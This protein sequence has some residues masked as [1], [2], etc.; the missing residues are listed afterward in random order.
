MINEYKVV[1]K[2]DI[3][4]SKENVLV[5]DDRVDNDIAKLYMLMIPQYT[6]SNHVGNRF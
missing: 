4:I 6:G 3:N 5:F 1:L 2:V